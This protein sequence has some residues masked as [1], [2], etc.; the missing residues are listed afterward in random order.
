MSYSFFKFWKTYIASPIEPK[1]DFLY[2]QDLEKKLSDKFHLTNEQFESLFY[3][4]GQIWEMKQWPFTLCHWY[5]MIDTIKDTAFFQT[6]MRLN[7]KEIT[8][9]KEREVRF[10]TNA[11]WKRYRITND[12]LKKREQVEKEQAKQNQKWREKS[13]WPIWFMLLLIA[14]LKN[15]KMIDWDIKID[16]NNDYMLYKGRHSHLDMGTLFWE[17]YLKHQVWIDNFSTLYNEIIT[18]DI[19]Q[20][21]N[22]NTIKIWEFSVLPRIDFKIEWIDNLSD[23]KNI[24]IENG[25]N[26]F[27]PKNWIQWNIKTCLFDYHAY[28]FKNFYI[29]DKGEEIVILS[30]PR[31]TAEK[32]HIPLSELKSFCQFRRSQVDITRLLENILSENP[33][34]EHIDSTR[35]N[36]TSN[37][38][39]T[40]KK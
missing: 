24:V 23:S 22:M 17:E 33:S 27:L 29:N 3:Q 16:H 35:T 8:K 12:E 9:W 30:N 13:E 28:A 4:N 10:P 5:A 15:Q 31:N 37:L 14:Y 11:K 26:F 2:Y 6:L 20:Y 19:N 40:Q 18:I 1:D 36:L 34:K 25:W 32:L 38:T 21:N 39:H 7:I